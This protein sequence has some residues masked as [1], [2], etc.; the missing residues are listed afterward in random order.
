LEYHA[1]IRSGTD[2]REDIILYANI[3]KSPDLFLLVV[4][5]E[6]NGQLL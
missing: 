3:K 6:A 5:V 2:S 4:D 1:Q